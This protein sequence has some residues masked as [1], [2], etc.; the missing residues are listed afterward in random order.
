MAE[1]SAAFK[2][3]EVAQCFTTHEAPT[4]WTQRTQHIF[5]TWCYSRSL[6]CFSFS[7]IYSIHTHTCWA[8][9][10]LICALCYIINRVKSAPWCLYTIQCILHQIEWDSSAQTTQIKSDPCV[11]VCVGDLVSFVNHWFSI[12]PIQIEIAA[13]HSA[14]RTKIPT[15]AWGR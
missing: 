13:K 6:S 12:N 14:V 4:L 9:V 1:P 11:C 7:H 5:Q 10:D 2:R 15:Q 8:H 3:H